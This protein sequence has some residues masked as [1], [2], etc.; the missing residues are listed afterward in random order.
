MVHRSRTNSS[1]IAGLPPRMSEPAYVLDAS[2]V[3]ALMLHEP[4]WEIV[5]E[6]LSDAC[7]SAAN[8]AEVIAKLVDRGSSRDEIDDSLAELDLDVRSLDLHQAVIAGHLRRSTRNGGLSLGD[9]ACLALA[10]M[11]AATALTT[12]RAWLQLDTRVAVELIR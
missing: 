2:A 4:G 7:I 3:L 10:G 9:R 11:L 1:P 8:L 12:D 5:A 6:R